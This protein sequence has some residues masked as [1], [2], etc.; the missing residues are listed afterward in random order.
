MPGAASLKK[1]TLQ[2]PPSGA[3]PLKRLSHQLAKHGAR[4]RWFVSPHAVRRFIER[5]APRLDYDGALESLIEQSVTAHFVKLTRHGGIDGF[6]LW[7]GPKP[8]RA[9]FVVHPGGSGLPVLVTVLFAF[10]R[11]PRC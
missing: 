9:R 4:G 10:D 1:L 2:Q 5:F 6:E 11:E 7:R 3:A 8:W